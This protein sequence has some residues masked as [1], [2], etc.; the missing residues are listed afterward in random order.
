[1]RYMVEEKETAAH[2]SPTERDPTHAVRV[3]SVRISF[4]TGGPRTHGYPIPWAPGSRSGLPSTS[5]G[6]PQWAQWAPVHI[7]RPFARPCERRGARKAV[8]N[9]G[10]R[11]Y[12]STPRL[13]GQGN[14]QDR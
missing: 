2:P 13:N 6:L 4:S 8:C 1:M 11:K 7:P 5:S 9:H 3:L 10:V 12:A 14:F